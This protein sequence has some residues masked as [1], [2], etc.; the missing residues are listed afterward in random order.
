MTTTKM[1]ISFRLSMYQIKLKQ[2]QVL[3]Q[4]LKQ[5][6]NWKPSEFQ[7]LKGLIKLKN[8]LQILAVP[9]IDFICCFLVKVFLILFHQTQS[10]LHID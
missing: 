2:T 7:E 3:W 1:E 5:L 6:R 4:G 9:E 8:V 10:F